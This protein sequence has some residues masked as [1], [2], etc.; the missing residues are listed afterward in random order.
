MFMSL[1]FRNN[2]PSDLLLI[3]TRNTSYGRH[4]A[5]LM[6]SVYALPMGGAHDKSAH[7]KIRKQKNTF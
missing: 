3:D 2:L 1:S 6:F 4:P 5:F 7:Y